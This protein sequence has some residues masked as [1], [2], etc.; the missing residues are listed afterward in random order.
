MLRKISQ[1]AIRNDGDDGNER[2]KGWKMMLKT[3]FV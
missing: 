1:E 3:V 2:K